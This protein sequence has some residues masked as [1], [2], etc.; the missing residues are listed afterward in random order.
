MYRADNENAWAKD[1]LINFVSRQPDLYDKFELA[2]IYLSYG[3]YDDMQ[4]VL[5]D[6][7]TTFE[8]DD[9]KTAELNEFSTVLNIVK[10]MHENNLYEE[11]LSESNRESMQTI[12]ANDKPITST[13]AL[14][15]LMRDNPSYEFTETVY[16]VEQNS[17]RMANP[18]IDNISNITNSEFKL[19]PNPA[20][21]YITL[22]YNCK[23]ANMT[24]SI[25]DIQG[26]ALI[27]AALKTIEDMSN[28]E[29]LVDLSKLSMGTYQI[30]I[31]SNNTILWSEKL[32]ITK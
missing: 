30:L 12:V 22:S 16:D 7:P 2:T 17:A 5:T 13:L 27:T 28:N 20:H 6:I 29:V 8:M 10:D 14:A 18:T 31:K 9:E 11:G 4:N 25:I 21:D 32:I 3:Q 1:S 23:F 19:Y 24:Y 26:K 15:L